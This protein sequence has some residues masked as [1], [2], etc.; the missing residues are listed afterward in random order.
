MAKPRNNFYHACSNIDNIHYGAESIVLAIETHTVLVYAFSPTDTE[1]T[2]FQGFKLHINC[3]DLEKD[4]G[5][6]IDDEDIKLELEFLAE[7]DVDLFIH[8]PLFKLFH[9]FPRTLASISLPTLYPGII[10]TLLL[11][12]PPKKRCSQSQGLQRLSLPATSTGWTGNHSLGASSLF[13]SMTKGVLGGVPPSA[14]GEEW[15]ALV[16][17][18]NT[19]IKKCRNHSAFAAKDEHH[20]HGIGYGGGRQVPGNVRINGEAKKAAMAKLM[21]DAGMQRVVGF[22]N[23]LFN[24]FDH[25]ISNLSN[26]EA[27]PAIKRS[28]STLF[29]LWVTHTVFQESMAYMFGLQERVTSYKGSGTVKY[30]FFAIPSF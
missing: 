17:R 11:L 27:L 1:S 30:W 12:Y 9:T 3:F 26:V 5:E 2:L 21:S 25:E 18:L 14:R 24:M 28:L 8:L 29:L 16:E 13:S 7:E 19:A 23:C 15:K 6:I 22:S 20:Q 4:A 10:T